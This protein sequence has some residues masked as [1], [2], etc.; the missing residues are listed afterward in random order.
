MQ[1]RACLLYTTHDTRHTGRTRDIA[2]GTYD[3]TGAEVQLRA[4]LL[5]TAQKMTTM[6]YFLAYKQR[7]LLIAFA[8]CVTGVQIVVFVLEAIL[9][10]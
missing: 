8:C 3:H 4:C 6:I 5:Y 1:L 10:L 7:V 2:H 9:L